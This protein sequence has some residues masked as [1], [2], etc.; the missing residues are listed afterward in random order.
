M[1]RTQQAEGT[2]ITHHKHGQACT[3]IAVFAAALPLLSACTADVAGGLVI[4]Q[5]QTPEGSEKGCLIPAEASM[6]PTLSGVFDISVGDQPAFYLYPLIRNGFPVT[7]TESTIEVNRVEYTGV[8]AKI[9]PPAGVVL[10]STAACPTEFT[11]PARASLLPEGEAGSAVQIILP[12]HAKAMD[13][14]FPQAQSR[15][16]LT[17]RFK[18]AVRALGKHGGSQI[19][20]DPFEY[21]VEVCKGC[22]Q[23]GSPD[24]AFNYP[25]TPAC[26]SIQMGAKP[27]AG[28][29]CNPAQDE[30]ILCCSLPTS[31]PANP[32]L[33]C[34]AVGTK[35]PV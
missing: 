23:L 20:S 18:V 25:N 7:A 13:A 3:L 26:S 28:N 33:V 29:A 16:A 11:F 2:L 32:K 35:P 12:C 5:N 1:N 17:L 24:P 8:Q 9:L 4:V 27:A 30:G 14:L 22:L 15:P 19:K 34:P 21:V 6:A 10:P 31:D